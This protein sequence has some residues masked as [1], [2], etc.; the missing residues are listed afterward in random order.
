M[1]RESGKGSFLWNVPTNRPQDHKKR[2]SLCDSVKP[3]LEQ[4]FYD[5]LMPIG[6]DHTHNNAGM[7]DK[8]EMK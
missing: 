2:Q 7:V 4:S 3:Q 8:R 6:L 1:R 5:L